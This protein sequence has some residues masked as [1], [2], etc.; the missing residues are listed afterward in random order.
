MILP[1]PH[2]SASG[3]GSDWAQKSPPPAS[4]PAWTSP[5]LKA[6]SFPLHHPSG[7]QAPAAFQCP[8]LNLP[9]PV[10]IAGIL[11]EFESGRSN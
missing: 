8:I 1:L 11:Y 10:Y 7:T 3:W 5:L 6:Q 2:T 4:S 9:S